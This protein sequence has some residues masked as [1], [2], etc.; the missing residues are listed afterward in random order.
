MPGLRENIEKKLRREP[1]I[2]EEFAALIPP[3]TPD[4]YSGLEQSIL[5]EGCRD[6]I[7]LWNNI[8]IDGHNRYRI[9]KAHNIPYR[10]ETKDFA[11]REEVVL[12]MFSNQLSRRNL[13]D[14]QRIEIVRKYEDTVKAQA[15]QRMLAG[16]A[17][18]SGFLRKGRAS[19]EL[20]EM[21]GVSASTYEHAVEVI[22][23]APAPVIEAVR[24]DELSINAAYAVTQMNT[25][26]QLEVSQRIE[27]GEKP[28][29]AISNVKKRKSRASFK[30]YFSEEDAE[31][32]KLLA[33]K[34]KK[35][36]CTVIVDL[37]REALKSKNTRK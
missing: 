16:K 34:S 26:E 22:N 19:D 20:G 4:E 15:R 23:K 13:S 37:V 27:N 21:A 6:A 31:Q 30:V 2:D 36:I 18:H 10:T 33:V 28:A 9:C 14:I 12:W 29:K 8:I 3:L 5:T 35:D 24:K 17:N 1:E 11:N 32:L 7:I 25:E